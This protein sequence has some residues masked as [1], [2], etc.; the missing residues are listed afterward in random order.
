MSIDDVVALVGRPPSGAAEAGGYFFRGGQF[1][2]S[3]QPQTHLVIWLLAATLFS[4]T[5]KELSIEVQ[6]C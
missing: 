5:V 6:L 4:W 3:Q 2:S 1:W